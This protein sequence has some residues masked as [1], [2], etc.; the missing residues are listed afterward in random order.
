MPIP[1]N[2]TKTERE[3]LVFIGAAIAGELDV[4]G[5]EIFDEA[6]RLLERI[7]AEERAAY[8]AEQRPNEDRVMGALA[9]FV[10]NCRDHEAAFALFRE[11][12]IILK[13]R[14]AHRCPN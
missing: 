3:L 2:M 12:R 5:S 6:E 9:V 14:D 8:C 13:R 7:T 10:K 11:I 4:P 1:D